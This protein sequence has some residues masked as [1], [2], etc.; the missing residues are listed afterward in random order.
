MLVP[1]AM[2]ELHNTHT[3][4]HK[5][6]SHDGAVG[7]ASRVFHRWPIHVEDVL[8]FVGKIRQFR[9]AGLHTIGHFILVDT[10][11]NFRIVVPIG[12]DGVQAAESIEHGASVGRFHSFWITEIEDRVARPSK[13]HAVVTARQKPAR[14]HAGE[15][16]LAVATV[17]KA[18]GEHHK[19]RQVVAFAAQTVGEPRA[20]GSFARDFAACHHKSAGRVVVDSVGVDGL[21]DGNVIDNTS[22][23]RQDI[24][25]GP[26][27][28]FARSLEGEFAGG[29]GKALLARCHGAEALAATHAFRQVFVEKFLQNRLVIPR[30][31]LR[32]GTVH[33]QVNQRFGCWLVM[34]KAG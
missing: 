2:Q 33:M 29:N 12:G 16:C 31:D 28:A 18:R 20:D 27:A 8:G 7:K 1:P 10:I 4:F 19:C 25:I 17:G 15:E 22:R 24:G 9:H 11:L 13:S 5:S 23:V 6:A 3:T 14:P 32:R 26:C 30:V 34:R 21:D